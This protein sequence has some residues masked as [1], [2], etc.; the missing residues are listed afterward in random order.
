ML[1]RPNFYDSK[2]AIKEANPSIA[3][4]SDTTI[5]EK[6]V[7]AFLYDGTPIFAHYV[8]DEITMMTW[9]VPILD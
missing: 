4:Y 5:D 3:A 2:D 1:F 6:D 8:F 9:A 7:F